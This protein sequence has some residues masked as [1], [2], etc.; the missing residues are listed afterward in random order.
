MLIIP[1]KLW[2]ISGH[3]L[4]AVLVFQLQYSRELFVRFMS[5]N[6]E[7]KTLTSA[8]QILLFVV[9]LSLLLRLIHTCFILIYSG[10]LKC[11]L[12][13]VLSPFIQSWACVKI[14]LWFLRPVDITEADGRKAKDGNKIWK[15]SLFHSVVLCFSLMLLFNFSLTEILVWVH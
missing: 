6:T 4:F 7:D 15:S 9:C 8:S 2:L 1:L 14:I 11:R 12:T 13:G 10:S 3:Y 5:S